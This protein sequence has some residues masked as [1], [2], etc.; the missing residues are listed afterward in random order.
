MKPREA[1]IDREEL[2]RTI[3]Y[4]PETGVFTWL[5]DRKNQVRAGSP[6]GKI[7]TAGHRQIRFLG[8]QYLAHR[9]AW[10]LVHGIWPSGEVDH[11]NLVKDDN[12]LINLRDVTRSQNQFNRIVR[13]DSRSGLKG[14]HCRKPGQYRVAIR[15]N[16]KRIRLGTFSTVEE[17]A[18]AYGEASQL[19]HGAFGRRS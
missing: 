10:F 12:R 17:A 19:H 7:N 2:A 8:R 18:A 16:G 9:L 14:V 13:A 1:H 5:I 3:N 4:D 11:I 15:A 6:A